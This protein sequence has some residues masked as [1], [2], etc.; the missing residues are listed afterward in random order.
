[1]FEHAF[2]HSSKARRTAINTLPHVGTVHSL[3]MM[4]DLHSHESKRSDGG[5]HSFHWGQARL[6]V[7]RGAEPGVLDC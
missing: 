7:A 4:H 5:I 6:I 2:E 3:F 1:M